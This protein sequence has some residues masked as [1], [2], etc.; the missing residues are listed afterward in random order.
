MEDYSAITGASAYYFDSNGDKQPLTITAGKL[1]LPSGVASFFVSVPTTQDTDLEGAEAFSLSAAITSGKSASDTS[2]ILD[3]GTGKV[4]DDKGTDSGAAGNDDRAITVAGLDDVSEGSNAI[5]TVTLPDGNARAT[6]ISLAL[7]NGS[8]TDNDYDPRYSAYYDDGLGNLIDLP[9]TDGKIVLP[10]GVTSFFVSVRTTDDTALEGAES[11]SLTATVTGGKSAS[12]T[13]TILDNGTGQ[14]YDAKGQ[15]PTGPGNDDT[16]A[17]PPA[18][19]PAPAPAPVPAPAPAPAPEIPPPPPAPAPAPAP[20]PVPLVINVEPSPPQETLRF[21]STTFVAQPSNQQPQLSAEVVALIQRSFSETEA[22]RTLTQATGFQVVV[23]ERQSGS[24][25]L[26]R[27]IDRQ[28]VETGSNGSISL[29]ADTFTHSDPNATIT[30]SAKR[31]DGRDLPNWVSFDPRTGTFKITPP[32][33][34]EGELEIEVTAR[35]E[36]GNEV[37]TQFKLNVGKKVALDGRSGLTEQLRTAAQ[38]Q[39]M[40]RD[41]VR[42]GEPA[43]APGREQASVQRAQ[44]VEA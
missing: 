23:N 35:D 18:P 42:G 3:D 7:S 21:D 41:S 32:P 43:P 17:P 26:T 37:K 15:N 11:F 8:A 31:P 9:V 16:P 22:P 20:A 2:T 4:Y 5:F 30:L 44:R 10:A 38:R 6:E 25:E 33:G 12:D 39:F 14:I 34:F 1:T 36:K 13:S 19:A 29:P 28:F 24:L 27:A 40:W